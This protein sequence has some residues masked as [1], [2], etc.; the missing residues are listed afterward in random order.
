MIKALNDDDS[1]LVPMMMV[2]MNDYSS[3]YLKERNCFWDKFLRFLQIFAKF[4]KWNICEK[5]TGSQF[6][7]LNPRKK[8][9][10]FFVFQNLQNLYFFIRE[11]LKLNPYELLKKLH[12]KYSLLKVAVPVEV[13]FCL[14]SGSGNKM[15]SAIS[16]YYLQFQED[17]FSAWAQYFMG[18]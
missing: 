11:L 12:T 18:L 7:K 9:K 1:N 5:F 8:K 10:R 3:K 14:G 2:P 16:V 13:L 15:I 4:L 6:T 17:P